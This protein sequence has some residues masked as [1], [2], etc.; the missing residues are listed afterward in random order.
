MFQ[1][2]CWWWWWQ[3]SVTAGFTSFHICQTHRAWPP[4]TLSSPKHEKHMTGK[5]YETDDDVI[6]TVRS[7]VED[8]PEKSCW[9]GIKKCFQRINYLGDVQTC[10]VFPRKK[11]VVTSLRLIWE[12]KNFSFT[13]RSMVPYLV[14]ALQSSALRIWAL[15]FAIQ[16]LKHNIELE[17]G[18]SLWLFAIVPVQRGY[19][20]FR[21][22]M[23]KWYLKK[24][25]KMQN[26][27]A[28]SI[29]RFFHI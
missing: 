22:S 25:I 10:Y 21:F 12:A 13:P 16:F 24:K 18:G 4:L 19:S 2:T 14:P 1:P 3:Q 23:L 6:G 28:L 5:R 9:N 20:F 27:S 26:S 7:H 8:L 17:V 11:I 15:K 29:C